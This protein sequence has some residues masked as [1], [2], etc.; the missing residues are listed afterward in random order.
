LNS[1]L[2]DIFKDRQV[3]IPTLDK[4]QV[5]LAAGG[6]F[7]G[8]ADPAWGPPS[9]GDTR[10]T[11][12]LHD[13]YGTHIGFAYRSPNIKFF[14]NTANQVRPTDML[15][16]L[17]HTSQAIQ[18]QDYALV[19]EGPLDFLRV[20]D[21]GI[22][23]VV[24]T[25]GA[26]MS[27]AQM[28]LLARFCKSVFLCYDPDDAGRLATAKAAALLKKGGLLPVPVTL[29]RDPDEFINKYG[30]DSLRKLCFQ[31]LSNIDKGLTLRI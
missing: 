14:Y 24:S 5:C 19:V 22:H 31:S 20:Y 27:W 9:F 15:Y 17:N 29:D 16:G 12:P 26:G 2:E 18:E 7:K 6:R 23:N 8:N 4:F 11:F 21:A 25:L 13:V 1:N 30:P 28:C 3:S 10:I